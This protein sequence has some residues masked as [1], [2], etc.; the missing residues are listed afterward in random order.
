MG[1][2]HIAILS[3]YQILIIYEGVLLLECLSHCTKTLT[4]SQYKDI[5]LK[6]QNYLFF[7]TLVFCLQ[8]RP[9]IYFWTYAFERN[10]HLQMN[11]I[12]RQSLM[13]LRNKEISLIYFHKI[14]RSVQINPQRNKTSSYHSPVEVA[15]FLGIPQQV[16]KQCTAFL[17]SR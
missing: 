1:L 11:K 13:A 2:F 15:K 5:P 8:K 14:P 17:F 3:L 16:D 10:Y 9:M 12:E 7:F 6:V 4:Q